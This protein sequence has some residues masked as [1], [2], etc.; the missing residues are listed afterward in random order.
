MK[1]ATVAILGMVVILMCVT[2][3]GCSYVIGTGNKE[4]RG[5]VLLNQAQK[6]NE[7]R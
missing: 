3:G 4:A 6:E 1:V 2:F 5:K 7:N